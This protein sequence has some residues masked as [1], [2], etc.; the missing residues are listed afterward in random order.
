MLLNSLYFTI[1]RI[2]GRYQKFEQNASPALTKPVSK[3]LL[4][5]L[6]MRE[7]FKF[8]FIKLLRYNKIMLI[9]R[10]K[11]LLIKTPINS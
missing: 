6:Y 11:I 2:L 5:V 9:M 3:T 4:L 8:D 7:K 1:Y 10:I